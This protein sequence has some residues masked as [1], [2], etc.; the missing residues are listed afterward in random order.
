MLDRVLN[1]LLCPSIHYNE[2]RKSRWLVTFYQM[3]FG[4]FPHRTSLYSTNLLAK[5]KLGNFE[6]KTVH[7]SHYLFRKCLQK[8]CQ[9]NK[10]VVSS[11][12]GL[13]GAL[14]VVMFKMPDKGTSKMYFTCV[15]RCAIALLSSASLYLERNMQYL[16]FGLVINL[17]FFS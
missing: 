9:R 4:K 1:T 16:K 10:R 17:N 6:S 11:Y 3:V 13:L 15:L 12:H 7:P 5:Q 14:Q 8:K 2:M